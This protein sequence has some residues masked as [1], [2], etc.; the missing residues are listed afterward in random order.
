MPCAGKLRANF[1][2]FCFMLEH[3]KKHKLGSIRCDKLKTD[4]ANQKLNMFYSMGCNY[5]GFKFL[6][7]IEAL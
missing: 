5:D 1:Y 2:P 7:F 3:Q 4:Y 6:N